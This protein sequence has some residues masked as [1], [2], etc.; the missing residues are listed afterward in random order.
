MSELL[1]AEELRALTG[2]RA[3]GRQDAWLTEQGIPHRR[4]AG[5]TIVSRTHVHAWLEGRPMKAS[6]GPNWA[7]LKHA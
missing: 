6:N 7:A 4:V 5:R 2:Y 3:A 1:S